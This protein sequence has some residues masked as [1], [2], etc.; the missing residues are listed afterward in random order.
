MGCVFSKYREL[1]DPPK[2]TT[3]TTNRLVHGEVIQLGTAG[4]SWP[5]QRMGFSQIEL[6]KG[7]DS[8]KPKKV[9]ES[10]VY[11]NNL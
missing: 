4:K 6:G 5:Q 7:D 11:E 1:I 2:T 10:T 8:W 3:F 9:Y